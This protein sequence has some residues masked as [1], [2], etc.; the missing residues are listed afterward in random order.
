VNVTWPFEHHEL[1]DT[2]AK[3]LGASVGEVMTAAAVTIDASASVEDAATLMHDNDLSRLPVVEAGRSTTTDGSGSFTFTGVA[4]PY[5]IAIVQTSSN[6]YAIVYAQLTRTDPT[7]SDFYLTLNA[8]RSTTVGGTL[9]VPS[10]APADAVTGVA[11][12]SPEASTGDYF[13]G[14]PWRLTVSWSGPTSTTGNVHA[15]Q[16][17]VDGNGTLSGVLAHGVKTGVTLANGSPVNNADVTLTPVATQPVTGAI[18]LPNGYSISSRSV[19]VGFSD[20]AAFPV[21][22]DTVSTPAFGFPIPSGIGASAVVSA[23]ASDG[24]AITAAQSPGLAPGT[25]NATL[26]LPSPALPT[27]PVNG[28]TGVDTST[29]FVW[30]PVVGGVQIALISGQG[31]D[32]VYVIVSGGTTARIPNLSAQGL[33]LPS[34][35]T[36]TWGVTALGPF[37][38]IDAFAVGPAREGVGYLTVSG[39][40]Q[41]TTK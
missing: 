11:F 9:T 33:G 34:G 1:D 19:Y 26:T 6:K 14:N 20:G 18:A 5:D 40:S 17:E 12:G 28:A 4:L 38:S 21:S 37:A 30:T 29:N 25:S 41:F 8:T 23:S 24:T 15:M 27:A 16:W 7:L 36:Y 10:P 35:R 39:D 2:M 32:P 3:A 31:T 13:T 22:D